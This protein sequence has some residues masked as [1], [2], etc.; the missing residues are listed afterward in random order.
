[1]RRSHGRLTTKA[2][3]EVT[4]PINEELVPYLVAS[5]AGTTCQWVCPRP[6]GER[7]GQDFGLQDYLR[8]AMAA[9]GVGVLEFVHYCRGWKCAH[10]ENHADDATRPCPRHGRTMFVTTQVRQVSFHDLRRSHAS[11][12]AEA[13][14]ATAVTQKLMRHSDPRLTQEVY[15]QVE[16]G[17]LQR[18]VNRL[19]FFP[20]RRTAN[21]QQNASPVPREPH[22]QP[23]DE[24]KWKEVTAL[25][26][27]PPTRIERVT[28]SL[29]NCCSTI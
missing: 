1:V 23:R 14:V 20:E 17:T 7:M 12:L 22:S 4:L 8:R 26:R 15:T 18:E 16:L 19:R 29:R 28:R 24:E 2:G 9:A 13:G 27:E 5:M 21:A 3:R 11:L 25:Q 10:R 6:D